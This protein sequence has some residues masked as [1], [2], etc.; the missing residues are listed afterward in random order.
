MMLSSA[1]CTKE[2]SEAKLTVFDN[3]ID[4]LLR[5]RT[6]VTMKVEPFRDENL[7]VHDLI[8][9]LKYEFSCR[10][11]FTRAAFMAGRDN[12]PIYG[13][14]ARDRTK[15][16]PLLMQVMVARLEH[17]SAQIL[18]FP[19]KKTRL[20]IPELLVIHD[21]SIFIMKSAVSLV[22]LYSVRRD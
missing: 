20:N 14:V 8:C 22:Y 11:V 15:A 17:L 10:A 6:K 3:S 4:G 21:S 5:D 12:S 2:L 18:I 19:S 16:S 1:K 7:G 9:T 13:Y